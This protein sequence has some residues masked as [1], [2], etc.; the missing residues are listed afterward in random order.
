MYVRICEFKVL[1][2][3]AITNL[4]TEEYLQ[5]SDMLMFVLKVS[6]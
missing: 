4:S 3:L 2:I 5:F 6:V 1:G